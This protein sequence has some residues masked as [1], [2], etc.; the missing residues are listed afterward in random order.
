MALVGYERGRG[1]DKRMKGGGRLQC[2]VFNLAKLCLLLRR[3][4]QVP[5]FD[6]LSL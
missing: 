3:V 2:F 1:R 5:V 6:L 4:I